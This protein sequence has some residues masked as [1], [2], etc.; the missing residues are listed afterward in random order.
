MGTNMRL[1]PLIHGIVSAKT[2]SELRSQFMDKAGQCI[3]AQ[4]WG[5]D[6]LDQRQKIVTSDLV[7]LPVSFCDRYQRIGRD[8]DLTSQKMIRQQIPVQMCSLSAQKHS[9]NRIQD[10]CRIYQIEHGVVAPI[11]GG[12]RLLGGIYFLRHP[13]YPSFQASDLLYISTFCQHLAVQLTTLR[14][15]HHTSTKPFALTHRESEIVD[16]VAQGFTNR[17]I[18]RCLF[19]STDGVKQALKRLYKKVGVSNRAALVA[20]LK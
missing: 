4:A 1:T 3:G 8:Q 19:I 12:G 5:L 11:L 14:F 17:E 9:P 15:I 6:L 2:E 13:G 16:L 18:S 10:L 7:G 20:K